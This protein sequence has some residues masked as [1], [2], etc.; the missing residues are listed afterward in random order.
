MQTT[1]KLYSLRYNDA[2]TYL[3]AALFVLGNLAL[4]RL[5]HL[6]PQGGV[7]WLPIYFFTLIGA[8]KYGW[9]VGLLTAIA[10]PLVNSMLFGMPAVSLLPAI[11]LKS[12]LLA[13][14][15]GV[16][17]S[18]FHKASFPLLIAVVFFY[19]VVGTWGEW[20]IN[21]DFFLAIQDFRMGIPGMLMQVFG[22]WLFINRIIRQ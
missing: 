7:T 14:A 12:G 10:S 22:G 5:F 11:L 15:S 16:A 13:I 2:K 18:R 21:G 3:A 8:Y 1:V 4:P 6:L 9:K 20:M 17:A 19:Q